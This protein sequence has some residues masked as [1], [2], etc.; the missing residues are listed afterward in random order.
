MNKQ[1]MLNYYEQ[2]NKADKYII[3]F[4]IKGFI[5]MAM[6]DRLNPDMITLEHA[7]KNQGESLRFRPKAEDKIKMAIQSICLCAKAQLID[8]KY[9]KG[10]MF[11]KIVTEYYHKEWKKDNIPFYESGDIN[12]DGEEV[13]IKLENASLATSKTINKLLGVA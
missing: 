7:S 12:I 4:S 2:F 6:V 10:E 3:G 8:E 11:E 1:E 5:Y 13:Q 9:N